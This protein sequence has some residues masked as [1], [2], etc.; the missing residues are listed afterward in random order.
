[1]DTEVMNELI[2]TGYC[3]NLQYYQS[4]EN[5]AEEDACGFAPPRAHFCVTIV[6]SDDDQVEGWG[7]SFD[8]AARD[9]LVGLQAQ[10]FEVYDDEQ[11]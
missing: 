4:L 9:A 10:E 7:D 2:A 3:W 5:G 11:D 1:M 8:D 6:T